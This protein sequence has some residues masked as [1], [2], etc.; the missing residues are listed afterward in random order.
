MNPVS[1]A[2]FFSLAFL[3]SSQA[4]A[5]NL[6]TDGFEITIQSKCEEGEVSC[7]K[8]IYNGVSRKTGQSIQLKGSSWHTLC[9]DGSPCRFLGYRFK[10]GNIVYYV[11]QD[12]TLEVIKDGEKVLVSE[13]GVWQE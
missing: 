10:N 11:H 3:A 5:R 2:L 7:D 6:I 13:K 1:T 9:D 8:Y 4:F 12:G